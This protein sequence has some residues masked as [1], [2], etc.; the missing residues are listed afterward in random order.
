[1]AAS[2]YD[3]SIEQGTSFRIALTY[4][5]DKKNPIDITGY[6][7]RLIWTTNT[8]QTQVFSTENTDP[9][10]YRFTIGGVDGKITL[11]LPATIT[12]TFDFSLARYDLE[13]RSDTDIYTGGGKEISRLLYG[14]VTIIKRNSK[15]ISE[16]DC[17]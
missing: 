7:S 13:L 9:S 6:C 3:F 8:G 15:I 5:D 17:A 14:T 2:K 4:K 12:N 16:I 1:M 11:M 10:L